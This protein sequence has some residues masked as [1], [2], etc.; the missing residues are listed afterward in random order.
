MRPL[1][2][3]LLAVAV[4][5]PAAAQAP[6]SSSSPPSGSE[7]RLEVALCPAAEARTWPLESR[8]GI[9]SLVLQNVA[10][11]HRG[12]PPVEVTALE[13][14]LLAGGTV[15]DSRRLAGQDLAA[16]AAAGPRLQ[17]SGQLELLAFQFC[18][19]QL[20]GDGVTL[21]GPALQ[22]G[23]ALLVAQ[24]PFA[25]KGDRDAVRVRVHGRHAGGEVAAAASLPVVTA[26]STTAYR[27][28]LAGAWFVAVGATPHT[29]HRWALPEEFGL[30]V[31]RLGEG[32]RTHSG[33]G[34]RFADYHAYGAVVRAAAAGRVV[35]A[36]DGIA[37]DPATLR[38][39]GESDDAFN[40]RVGESQMA[41]ILRGLDA[42]AGN[43]VVIRHG[44]RE[45]SVYAHLVPG[46]LL[47]KPGDAVKAGQPIGRLGSSG[48][49]TEPHLHFHVCDRPSALA[50]AGV[51]VEFAGIRLPWADYPRPL[52]SGDLVVA[53]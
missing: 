32:N 6:P 53:E 7:P 36:V 27:F 43:H 2:L 39:P 16:I 42:I 35:A 38:R 48:N 23:Q 4:A 31:V 12:G 3:C 17:A 29:A 52:Q 49:S 25:F 10:V 13:V 8:R 15:V 50:C 34:T 47:V 26:A 37:E 9:H 21:A 33:D 20:I 46:S 1:A 51:P 28:P 30:D 18:G 40:Q 5:A 22:P 24:Q 44:E 41:A 11:H 14:E 19:E 45:H